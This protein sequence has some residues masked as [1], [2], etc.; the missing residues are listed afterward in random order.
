MNWNLVYKWQSVN[1][2]SA[3]HDNRAERHVPD[4]N[5]AAMPGAV[6]HDTRSHRWLFAS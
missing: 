5:A 3:V 1:F 6:R 2:Q 4:K